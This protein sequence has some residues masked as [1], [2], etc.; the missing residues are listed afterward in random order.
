MPKEHCRRDLMSEKDKAAFSLA[1]LEKLAGRTAGE[2]GSVSR[3]AVAIPL[4]E[5]E[6]GLY[7]LFELRSPDLDRQPGEICLPGGAREGDESAEETALRETA[8]ELLVD[9]SQLRVIAPMDTLRTCYRNE[10]RAFLCELKNYKDTWSKDEV[11]EVFAVPLQ[12]FL[13]TEPDCYTNELRVVMQDDFPF[14]KIPGGKDYPWHPMH[15]MV[16]FYYYDQW[17]IWGLTAKIMRAAAKV[18]REALS[19]R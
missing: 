3:F 1:A 10:I 16:Y 6:D 11:A 15:D 17:V 5:K 18:I 8:E 7:V 19:L 4:V 9:R 13:D 14:D 12:F 2:I